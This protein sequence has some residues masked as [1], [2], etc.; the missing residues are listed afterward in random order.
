[1]I[2]GIS[3]SI[4]IGGFIGAGDSAEKYDVYTYLN[5][6][7][8]SKLNEIINEIDLMPYGS[9]VYNNTRYSWY[10]ET[11]YFN[12]GIEKKTLII[13]WTDKNGQKSYSLSR[14]VLDY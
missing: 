7:S 9:F 4:L 10:L 8:A 12:G 3:F 2:I 5:I 6:W 11:R 14:L 13:E 1:M